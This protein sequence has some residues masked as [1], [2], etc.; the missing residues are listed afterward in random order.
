MSERVEM[1]RW[2]SRTSEQFLGV[3]VQP[4]A[5]ERLACPR[6]EHE[7]VFLPTRPGREAAFELPDPMRPQN[8]NHRLR[9]SN[10]APALLR[11]GFEEPPAFSKSLERVTDAQHPPLELHVLP[12]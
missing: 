2:Q 7:I 10:R 8:R 5:F 6:R 1:N 11:F 4:D 12:A 3:P 9:K